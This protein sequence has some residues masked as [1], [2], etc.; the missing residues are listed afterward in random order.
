MKTSLKTFR[1]DFTEQ[2]LNFVWHQWCRMGVAGSVTQKPGW[3][4]DPE[5]LLAFTSEVARHDARMFDQVLDWLATN[6]HWIN[7]QRLSTL[8]KQGDIGDTAVVGGIACWMT[9]RDKS[10]KWRGVSRTFNPPAQKPAEALFHAQPSV[11]PD[12]LGPPCPQFQRYGLIR[13]PIRTREMTQPVNMK[14]PANVMFKSR[15]IFG[16]GIRADVT[17][18][19]ATANGGHARQIADVLGYNHARVADVL[20]EMAEAGMVAMHSAGQ[21]KLYRIDREQWRSILVPGRAEALP[22]VNWRYLTRGLTT[23]WRE[24]WALDEQRADDYVFSSEARKAMQAAHDD[25]LNSGIPFAIEDHRAHVAESYLPIFQA[26]IDAIMRLL[27]GEAGI[28]R[29]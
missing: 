12:L 28:A 25:L 21:A 20:A 1:H 19:L 5:P 18:Y 4:I 14:D 16:I 27:A 8:V 13:G 2:M 7:T 23:L 22:W 10:A 26:D 6:G 3:V 9:E 29:A 17:A 24:V 15:A 11:S